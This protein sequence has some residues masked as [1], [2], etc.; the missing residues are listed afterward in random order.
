M[1]N[2]NSWVIHLH[3]ILD[4]KKKGRIGTQDGGAIPGGR[5]YCLVEVGRNV[6]LY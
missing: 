5:I 4:S 6:F 2:Y 3:K 1:D